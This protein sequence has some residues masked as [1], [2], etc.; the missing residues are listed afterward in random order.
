M[1]H[2]EDLLT[3][4]KKMWSV[5]VKSRQLTQSA[6]LYSAS[7]LHINSARL[8]GDSASRGGCNSPVHAWVPNS[9]G[10]LIHT[11]RDAASRLFPTLAALERSRDRDVEVTCP[12]V[13][14][15][16]GCGG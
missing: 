14:V 2:Q 16:F 3:S 15:S 13:L 6:T 1:R 9:T 8:T 7:A 5:F 4:E 10:C 11:P 12:V